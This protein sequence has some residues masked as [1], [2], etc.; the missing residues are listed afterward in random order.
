MAQSR[1]TEAAEGWALALV[2]TWR[3]EYIG[4]RNEVFWD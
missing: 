3:R 2:H 1:T 4:A